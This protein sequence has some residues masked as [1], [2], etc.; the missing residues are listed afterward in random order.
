MIRPRRYGGYTEKQ[1][2]EMESQ[3]GPRY[4]R[5]GGTING[6]Q[7]AYDLAARLALP[8]MLDTI[9][10]LAATL[11]ETLIVLGYRRGSRVDKIRLRARKLIEEVTQ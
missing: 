7:A 1:L 4:Q 8:D 9:D 3:A 11:T 5:T 10:E 6:A 2:R